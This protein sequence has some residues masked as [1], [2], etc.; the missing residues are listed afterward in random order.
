MLAIEYDGDE[1]HS[2]PEQIEHDRARR[3][4][5][6]TEGW[7]TVPLG[8]EE[9]FGRQRMCD[10]IIRE[11]AREARARRGVRAAGSAEAPTRHL[12]GLQ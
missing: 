1:W 10:R 2:S 7:L 9:V 4:D 3:A 11:A 6:A 12:Y 5:L 8:C